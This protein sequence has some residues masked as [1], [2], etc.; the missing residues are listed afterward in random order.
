M[1][2]LHIAALYAGLLL[3]LL[4]FLGVRTANTRRAKQIGHGDNGDA[5]LRRAVRAHGNASEYIPAGLLG[6]LILAILP[7]VSVLWVQA[8]GAALLTGR[9]LS[10]YGLT[11][12]DGVSFGRVSGMLLTLISYVIAAAGLIWTAVEPVV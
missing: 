9:L 4:A 11:T 5:E 3:L 7:G 8:A 6:L 10:A 12:K 2:N 1:T